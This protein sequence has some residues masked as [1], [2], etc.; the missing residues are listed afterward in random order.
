MSLKHPD[1]TT[2]NIDW[3]FNDILKGTCAVVMIYKL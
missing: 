1:R 3:R 2:H